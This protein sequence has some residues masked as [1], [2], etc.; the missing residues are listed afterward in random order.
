MAFAYFTSADKG[1][2]R[3]FVYRFVTHD[4]CAAAVAAHNSALAAE[5]DDDH[6]LWLINEQ[7]KGLLEGDGA[8]EDH[9]A[10][11][12]FLRAT[13]LPADTVSRMHH[14]L[15]HGDSKVRSL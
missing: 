1:R 8:D 4:E 9:K 10:V 3:Q 7:I 11:I 15:V 13:G 14:A 12:A 5:L 2:S 6:P